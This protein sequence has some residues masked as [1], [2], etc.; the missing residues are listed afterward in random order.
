[1]R[2]FY[3]LQG[4]IAI[5][6]KTSAAKRGLASPDRWES[7]V[8]AF[9]VEPYES[10]AKSLALAG[11]APVPANGQVLTTDQRDEELERERRMDTGEQYTNPSRFSH[12]KGAW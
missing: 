3:D 1:M 5:E 8:L 12:I 4:H 2:F 9:G 10:L 6:P 7:V 11:Y